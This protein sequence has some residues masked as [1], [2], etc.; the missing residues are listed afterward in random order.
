MRSIV[1]PT[2]MQTGIAISRPPSTTTGPGRPLGTS[3][4]MAV[5]AVSAP[6]ITTSPW[7]KLI[8]PRMP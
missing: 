5:S 6:I 2:V 7:A 4:P 1:K 8:R 3:R